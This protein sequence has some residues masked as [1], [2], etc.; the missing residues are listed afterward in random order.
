MI[1]HYTAFPKDTDCYSCIGCSRC[2]NKNFKGVAICHSY[3]SCEIK[4][5]L[6]D[7]AVKQFQQRKINKKGE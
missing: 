3:R 4:N 7:D 6:I 2:E 1:T 5:K